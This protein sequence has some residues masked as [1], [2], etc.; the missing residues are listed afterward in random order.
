MLACM[1]VWLLARF[2]P[3]ACGRLIV[4][5]RRGK[6][7][8][9]SSAYGCV[10]MDALAL[11]QLAQARCGDNALEQLCFWSGVA[12]AVGMAAWLVACEMRRHD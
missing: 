12:Y 5:S 6:D 4:A 8:S 3:S 9:S 7:L 10:V 1:C 2:S 11:E